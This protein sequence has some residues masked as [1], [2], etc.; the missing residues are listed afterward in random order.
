MTIRF[1]NQTIQFTDNS[2]LYTLNVPD[3]KVTFDAGAPVATTVFNTGT[4]TWET[5]SQPALAGNTFL[6][7][8]AFQV[9]VNFSG[10]I[11]PVTWSGTFSSDTSGITFH[12]QWAAAVYTTFSTNYNALGV[13][14]V[15]DNMASI[16]QNSDHAGTPENFKAFVT[17]G[18]RGGGGSNFTGSLS[19]TASVS[20]LCMNVSSFSAQGITRAGATAAAR[21]P[22]GL[23][24]VRGKL[25][26]DPSTLAFD[27]GLGC[28]VRVK[29]SS[30][31]DRTFAFTSGECEVP[32]PGRMVC[33][34]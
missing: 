5:V 6:S 10:G 9:P 31:F 14:P 19:A 23:I 29:D 11:N 20:C 27:A 21:A 26:G 18:A 24:N 3:A 33:R 17:G 7:G 32:V 4:N 8:L 2:V 25:R 28:W 13:K 15:D 1:T 12:W 34:S 22:A 30:S 16:Y